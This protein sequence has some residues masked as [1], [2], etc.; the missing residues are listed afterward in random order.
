MTAP[1][2]A[3]ARAAPSARRAGPGAAPR[4]ASLPPRP[5]HRLRHFEGCWCSCCSRDECSCSACL[6]CA[7]R[8]VRRRCR[9]K[10]PLPATAAAQ[11]ASAA[12]AARRRVK[13]GRWGPAV[14]H[15]R[16]PLPAAPPGA[17]RAPHRPRPAAGTSAGFASTFPGRRGHRGPQSPAVR[18][19]RGRPRTGGQQVRVCGAGAAPTPGHGRAVLEPP[20]DP[21]PARPRPRG[22]T[23]TLPCPALPRPHPPG[24]RRGR[25]SPSR[26][27][28]RGRRPA[29]G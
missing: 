27:M 8:P 7:E 29:Q 15:R 17:C 2:G 18:A 12:P 21:I 16:R 20:C 14:T 24:P 4:S 26:W 22:E 13:Y 6:A 9:R 11:P 19:G 28:A 10:E 3:R 25:R 23:P 1:P 5:T